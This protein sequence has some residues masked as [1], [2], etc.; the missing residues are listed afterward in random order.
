MYTRYSIRN[1]NSNVKFTFA[2]KHRKRERELHRTLRYFKLSA[3]LNKNIG[4][5]DK[6]VVPL[7]CIEFTSA[8]NDAPQIEYNFINYFPSE[9]VLRHDACVILDL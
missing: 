1:L 6:N 7:L 2:S 3:D 4:M 8:S 5:N 9:C